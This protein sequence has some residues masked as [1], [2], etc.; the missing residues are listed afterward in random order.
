MKGYLPWVPIALDG[1]K[2]CGT[3]PIRD[4]GDAC[5]H[6]GAFDARLDFSPDGAA[7]RCKTCLT[8]AVPSG[9][10]DAPTGPGM[11]VA[12]RQSDGLQLSGQVYDIEGVVRF[13]GVYLDNG[14]P[15]YVVLPSHE[16]GRFRWYPVTLPEEK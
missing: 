2:A 1:D 3:C 11:W 12:V 14:K 16:F 7:M 5:D 6:C 13:H 10:Y 4:F 9:G 15:A 8:N